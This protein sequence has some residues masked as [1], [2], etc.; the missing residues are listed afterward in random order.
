MSFHYSKDDDTVGPVS[1]EEL[2]AAVAHDL[3]GEGLYVWHED[4]GDDWNLVASAAEVDALVSRLPEKGGDGGSDGEDLPA[5]WQAHLDESSGEYYYFNPDTGMTSW[6]RPEVPAEALS[7]PDETSPAAPATL[8]PA[9]AAPTRHEET[10]QHDDLS[11]M[12]HKIQ[13]EAKLQA[14]QEAS[15][16]LASGNLYAI[17]DNSDGGKTI[18]KH[19]Y[20]GGWPDVYADR[21]LPDGDTWLDVLRNVRSAGGVFE[22][23]AFPASDA[24]IWRDPLQKAASPYANQLKEAVAWRRIPDVLHQ[25][26]HI[27]FTFNM[28]PIARQESPLVSGI[29]VSLDDEVKALH[30]AHGNGSEDGGVSAGAGSLIKTGMPDAGS[31]PAHHPAEKYLRVAQAAATA[32]VALDRAAL[33]TMCSQGVVSWLDAQPAGGMAAMGEMNGRGGR[34]N[35]DVFWGSLKDIAAPAEFREFGSALVWKEEPQDAGV[36]PFVRLVLTL[37]FAPRRI[38]LFERDS[39]SRPLV[40][41][42]DVRQGILGD[43]YFLGALSVVASHTD[44][45]FD[46]FP[47]LTPDLVRDDQVVEGTPPNEQEAN[48]EGLYAVRFWREGKWRIV[49]VDDRIPVDAAGRPCFAQLPEHGCEIWVLLAEKAFAKLNGSY[50]AIIAGHENEALQD[51]TGGLPQTFKLRGDKDA[52]SEPIGA[53]KLWQEL[54]AFGD[55]DETNLICASTNKAQSGIMAGHAY[56][57]I[58]MKEVALV[59]GAGQ[60]RLIH[61][62]NPWGKGEEWTGRF[63]DNDAESW[64][65]VGAAVQA[66]L[67]MAIEDDGTWWMELADFHA[68]FSLVNVCRILRQPHWTGHHATGEWYGDEAPGGQTS[69]QNAQYQLLLHED[70]TVFVNVGQP[71]ARARTGAYKFA[72]GPLVESCSEPG[73]PCPGRRTYEVGLTKNRLGAK[74]ELDREC[75]VELELKASDQPYLIVPIT[76]RVGDM[77]IF[78]VSVFT[79]GRSDFLAVEDGKSGYTHET[80]LRLTIPA[81]LSGGCYPNNSSWWINPQYLLR[82]DI[83]GAAAGMHGKRD[84]LIVLDNAAATDRKDRRDSEAVLSSM[85]PMGFALFQ[86]QNEYVVT[87]VKPTD[88]VGTSDIAPRPTIRKNFHLEPGLY[89]VLPFTFEKNVELDFCL[90]AF[91]DAPLAPLE[92]VVSWPCHAVFAGEWTDSLSGGWYV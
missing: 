10:L 91:S 44:M 63:S 13:S 54:N 61:V 14:Q 69:Y 89:M 64:S 60:A 29:A 3:D 56:A 23:T 11:H 83:A 45:L 8:A 57:I 4:L 79:S 65:T 77:S 28:L 70:S 34:T 32:G 7:A 87:S 12:I 31:G 24:S 30:K 25:A 49:I 62:R 58:D 42:G 73:L 66:E 51:I 33:N 27:K 35:F 46:V 39:P 71:S 41:P 81:K 80:E 85:I 90:N 55:A 75:C 36:V 88:H 9:L 6:D 20:R 15:D 17:S 59:G 37:K 43:C 67:G 76:Q 18:E 84:V 38:Q 40:A 82:V 86:M 16:A 53:E 48:D 72:M 1:L 78:F 19:A 21:S 5:P 68:T 26:V 52:G 74:L 92:S 47:D 2:R 50:E 22:D